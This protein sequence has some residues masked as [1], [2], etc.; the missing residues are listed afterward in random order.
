VKQLI[1]PFF[2]RALDFTHFRGPAV[3][4]ARGHVENDRPGT[5]LQVD[6]EAEQAALH[7]FNSDRLTLQLGVED[8]TYRFSNVLARA[9]GG[10]LTGTVV[11]VL[12][13]N[14]PPAYEVAAGATNLQLA[15]LIKAVRPDDPGEQQG[16]V[17]ASVHLS[18]LAGEGLGSSVT[19]TGRV[20]VTDGQL[21][22]IRLLGGL[23]SLLSAIAP[24]LG[25]ASQTGFESDFVIRKGRCETQDA[26]LS[27][28]VL[29]IRVT[30]AYFFDQ[31]VKFVVEVKPL[32][33]GSVATVLRW[34]TSPITRLF[35]FRLTGTLADPQWR[36][37][38]LPKEM[39]LIFD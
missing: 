11:L 17:A 3:I 24:G 31:R 30:G 33:G 10:A 19:G 26:M 39:F 28:S 15:A 29:S 34:V 16:R 5:R 38:N 4:G 36:P 37:N 13:S 32:R 8:S 23:S 22:R 18:G 25:M 27:G 12:S 1:G 6:I 9:Y 21:S 35:S 7:W 14:A 20:S 2:V